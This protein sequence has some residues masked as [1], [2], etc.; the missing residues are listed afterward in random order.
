MIPQSGAQ[1][2]RN[3]I[4]NN[5]CGGKGRFVVMIPKMNGIC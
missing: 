3:D 4:L 5:K 1:A 2:L